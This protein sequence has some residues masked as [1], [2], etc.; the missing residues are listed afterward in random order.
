M[1]KFTIPIAEPKCYRQAIKDE[2]WIQAMKQEIQALE[3]NKTW[4]VIDLPNGKNTVSSKWV[5][6]VKYKAN[7]EMERFKARLVV[8]GYSQQEGWDYHDTFSPVAKM[9]TVRCVIVLTVSKG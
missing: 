7:G 4:L 8:E 9:V 2:K 6:K 5:Y 3:D 1:S